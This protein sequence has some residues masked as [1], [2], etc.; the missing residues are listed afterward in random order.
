[1]GKDGARWGKIGM[2]QDGSK[3]G[4]MGKKKGKKGKMEWV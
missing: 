4:K 1:M 3:T 2:D